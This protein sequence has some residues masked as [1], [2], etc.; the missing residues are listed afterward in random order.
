MSEN[1]KI[2]INEFN[3]NGLVQ[4]SFGMVMLFLKSAFK[5]RIHGAKKNKTYISKSKR[6]RNIKIRFKRCAINNVVY[7]DENFEGKLSI[8]I[9]GNNNNVF[10][11]KNTSLSG[12]VISIYQNDSIVSIGSDV[13]IGNNNNIEVSEFNYSPSLIIGNDCMISYNVTIRLSD[14][15]PIYNLSNERINI[16]SDLSIGKHVWIGH[17]TTILKSVSIG[18]GCI[19]GTSSLITKS[20]PKYSIAAGNPGKVIRQGDFYWCRTEDK[21]HIQQARSFYSMIE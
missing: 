10:I 5:I 18:D 16:G 4:S 1:S 6:K 7:I 20:I 15:H 17:D 19:I 2:Y 12:T 13:S 11:G 9:D 8:T 14:A 21:N 3:S